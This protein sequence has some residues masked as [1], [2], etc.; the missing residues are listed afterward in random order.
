MLANTQNKWNKQASSPSWFLLHR[1]AAGTHETECLENQIW[2]KYSSYLQNAILK[3]IRLHFS[4]ILPKF[5]IDCLYVTM[6]HESL[7]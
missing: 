4:F 3:N 1:S 7:L 5:Y 2:W 6:F